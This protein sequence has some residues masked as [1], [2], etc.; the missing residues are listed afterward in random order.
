MSWFCESIL[1]DRTG[2]GRTP[3]RHRI[4]RLNYLGQTV[5][6]LPGRHGMRI[7]DAVAEEWNRTRY[8]PSVLSMPKCAGD[9]GPASRRRVQAG[10]RSW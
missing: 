9:L 6:I 3:I 8:R 10:D 4:N 1:S 7:L 5:H 2:P